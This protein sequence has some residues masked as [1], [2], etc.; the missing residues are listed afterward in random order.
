M[1][2]GFARKQQGIIV[3]ATVEVSLAKTFV[4][5]TPTGQEPLRSL[6]KVGSAMAEWHS[7]FSLPYSVHVCIWV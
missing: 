2:H 3:T 5:Q 7:E 6:S 4:I 1:L